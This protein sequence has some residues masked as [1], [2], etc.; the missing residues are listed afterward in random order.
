MQALRSH[1]ERHG[2]SG[3]AVSP[4]PFGVLFY[5]LTPALRDALLKLQGQ[6]FMG[7]ECRFTREGFASLEEVDTVVL[8]EEVIPLGR[9]GKESNAYR[10]LGDRFPDLER[11]VLEAVHDAK[12]WYTP[13]GDALMVPDLLTEEH[14]ATPWRHV[15]IS[16][17]RDP[18][19]ESEELGLS[20][21]FSLLGAFRQ[22][23]SFQEQA[24]EL[25]YS[26]IQTLATTCAVPDPRKLS[27]EKTRKLA[28]QV[29]LA[30]MHAL[31]GRDPPA[32]PVPPRD[33]V[34]YMIARDE[35]LHL[36]SLLSLS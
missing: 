36:L 35:D 31:G 1:L 7:K 16:F 33:K 5:E 34:D 11:G 17:S 10:T 23:R 32:A 8:E 26:P 18:T 9:S 13:A 2:C 30:W 6:S 3:R 27:Q 20:P 28:G 4:A 19:K 14:R 12:G 22:A 25:G 24:E 15:I 21:Y 29:A